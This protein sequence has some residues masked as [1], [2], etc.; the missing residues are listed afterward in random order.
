MTP[1][2]LRHTSHAPSMRRSNVGLVIVGLA[3]LMYYVMQVNALAAHAWKMKDANERL[4]V[5][6]EEHNFLVAQEAAL[7]D[8]QALA[9]LA[10]HEGLIPADAVVYLVQ[11]HAVAAK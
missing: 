4:G 9:T 7:D 5:L 10:A 6:R 2:H 11:D 1:T 8:R 3:L